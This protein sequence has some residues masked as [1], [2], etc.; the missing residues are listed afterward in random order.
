MNIVKHFAGITLSTLLLTATTASFAQGDLDLDNEETRIAY[1]IGV[2][3]GQ[4][5]VAQGLL[6]GIEL[7]SFI[8]GLRAVV[9]D[10]VELSEEQ[11]IAAIQLFQERMNAQAQEAVAV[12]R[13]ASEEFLQQN[14]TREGVVTLDSGLQYMVITDGP[15]GG[16]SPGLE[17]SVLAHY[18]GTLPD[19]SIFDSSVDRGEPA[20]F[21]VSQVI[22]GWTE[23]LQLMKLGDKWRLFIPSDL[24]Y[25]ENS[26]SPAIPPSSALIFD[27]E[28]LE[29]R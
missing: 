27:V 28:L 26:P 4:S 10:N 20:Q 24:A 29:I 19:G 11:M 7:D 21:G 9:S 23:A 17:D 14:A 12:S 22:A 15:A 13:A 25:G 1:A 16:D 3:I 18:H 5:L 6:G 8:T 2:N